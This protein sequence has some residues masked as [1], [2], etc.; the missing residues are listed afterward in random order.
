MSD[1][2][3]DPI[4]SQRTWAWQIAVFFRSL[5]VAGCNATG[6]VTQR[7]LAACGASLD[8]GTEKIV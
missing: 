3:A 2:I 7:P 8:S 6:V 5:L 1:A 4:G